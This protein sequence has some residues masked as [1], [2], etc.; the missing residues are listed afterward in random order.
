MA[1]V[2]TQ[3]PPKHKNNATYIITPPLTNVQSPQTIRLVECRSLISGDGHTG[4]RTWEAACA[5]GELL[6]SSHYTIANTSTISNDPDFF[7]LDLTGKNVLELG[8]GTGFLSMLSAKLG[9]KQVV[10]TDGSWQVCSSLRGN[11]TEN[12]LEEIVKVGRLLWGNGKIEESEDADNET[13]ALNTFVPDVVLA[14][15]VV[16]LRSIFSHAWCGGF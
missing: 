15:D 7:E 13:S 14:S 12:G 4:S 3:T 6:I 8:A 1:Q 2:P 11:V 9:A 10:A 16:C 5:L